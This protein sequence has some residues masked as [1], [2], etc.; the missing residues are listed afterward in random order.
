M[1]ADLVAELLVLIRPHVRLHHRG[2][3]MLTAP[4]DVRFSDLRVVQPDIVYFSPERRHLLT[5]ARAISGAPDLAVEVVSPF[6]R[7]HDL[8]EKFD[9]HER[10]GVREY[11]I[12][13]PDDESLRLFA[14]E[15]DRFVERPN[16][17]GLARSVVRPGLAV[18][19]AALL[20]DPR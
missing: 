11:W 16:R 13:D 18:D 2:G 19:I 17:D 10:M 5:K 1:H 9:L 7:G 12:V 3:T 6:N 20:A 14:L 15:A 4:V 8:N